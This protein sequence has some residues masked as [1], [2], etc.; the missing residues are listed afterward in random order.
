MGK[1]PH[2]CVWT[3]GH[4]LIWMSI[5]TFPPS[6]GRKSLS[7]AG[8]WNLNPQYIYDDA[9]NF[10]LT[11]Y[12][13]VRQYSKV[14]NF[15]FSQTGECHIS[16]VLAKYLPDT[17]FCWAIG[18]V[19]LHEMD[20][21]DVAPSDGACLCGR[22]NF[23]SST[24]TWT[25]IPTLPIMVSFLNVTAAAVKYVETYRVKLDTALHC[26]VSLPDTFIW[27]GQTCSVRVTADKGLCGRFGLCQWPAAVGCRQRHL[28]YPTSPPRKVRAVANQPTAWRNRR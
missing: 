26:T 9:D 5:R 14:S 28:A 11:P 17:T 3:E 25:G 18:F 6:A 13:K 16:N 1:G 4:T 22:N 2:R 20:A 12:Y 21:F 24:K 15:V 8:L 10:I 23:Y 27:H 19:L 7:S